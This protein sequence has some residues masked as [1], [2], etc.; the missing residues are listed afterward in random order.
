MS[1][2]QPTRYPGVFTR[3]TKRTG[4]K[5]SELV[6]YIVFKKDG[7]IFEEKV[8]KQ[9]VDDMTPARAASIRADRIEGKRQSRKDLRKAEEEAKRAESDR[10]TIERLWEEYKASKPGLKGIVTDENRFKNFIRPA[11][12]HKEPSQIIALDVDRLRVKLLKTHKPGTVKNV[13]ELLRRIINYACKKNLCAGPGFTVELPKA[14]S[15]KTETLTPEQITALLKAIEEDTHPQAGPMMKLALFSGL[16]KSEMFKLRWVDLDFRSG[17][18]HMPDAKSGKDEKIPMS[19][20]AREIL[21]ATPR[22][23][24][25]VFPGRGGGRRMYI[26]RHV[27]AIRD[28]AGLPKDFRAFHGLRHVYASML[29]SSGKVDMYTLQK[30]MTHKSPAMTQRYAHLRDDALHRAAD[31]TGEIF[32]QLTANGKDAE[33]KS[34]VVNLDNRNQGGYSK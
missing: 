25:Y 31:V 1:K 27:N 30:L 20:P 11:F 6:Y 13:L 23:A 28:R 33:K 9:Y 7:R 12:G 24:D 22:A 14:Q 4:G 8:G 3:E 16:R 26:Q 29:A 2:R 19:P 5:G 21:E 32:E 10:W 15:L 34:K 18:I 17:F